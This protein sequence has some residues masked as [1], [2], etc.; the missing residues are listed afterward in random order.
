MNC[1]RR[2]A[3]R[4]LAGAAAAA[5]ALRGAAAQVPTWPARTVRIIV[6]YPP[7]GATDILARLLAESLSRRW[8]QPVIVENRA[9]AAGSIGA[10]AV[11]KSPPDGYTILMS[12]SPEIAIAQS[13]NRSLP[14]DPVAD[15]QPVT[16]LAHAPFALLST[17]ALPA[18][19]LAE[20]IALAKA[21]PGRF[22]FASYGVGASNHLVGELF[23]QTAGV[24]IRHV[25]Y[26]GSAPAMADLMAGHVQIM[27]DN[28][29]SALAHV[30][31]GR[32]RAL[33]VAMPARSPRAPD[34]PTFTE[35]GMA[36]FVA[37]SWI[38]L[39][40]PA[41]T[42]EPIVTRFWTDVSEVMRAGFADAIRERGLEPASMTPT[43]FGA[44]IRS[45]VGRWGQVVQ[46][47]GIRPE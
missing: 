19:T 43:E 2:A 30:Q 17:P 34:V 9:G 3:L 28:F 5:P 25:P 32:V 40:L 6:G 41:R 14:Y 23:A 4:L 18:T 1:G 47:A 44:F 35:A 38:A 36:G 21:Q 10:D 27:F 13:L 33:A 39:L 42:P 37:A 24:D 11:A 12:G 26:R 31:G 20:F 29:G 46:R 16:L 22:N 45:E 15:F 7:G 8:G